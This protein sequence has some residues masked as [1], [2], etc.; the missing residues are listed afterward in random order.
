MS[1]LCGLRKE[2]QVLQLP[3]WANSHQQRKNLYKKEGRL[4][5]AGE[6]RHTGSIGQGQGAFIRGV[7]E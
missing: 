5:T 3:Q 4:S 1:G 7:E 2:R 6:Q